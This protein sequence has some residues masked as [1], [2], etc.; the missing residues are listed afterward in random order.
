MSRFTRGFAG[1]GR[2]HDPRL[3]PGQYDTGRS[4]PVLT[5]EVTPRIDTASWTF[6]VEGLV[7]QPTTWTWDQIHALPQADYNGAIHCVTT[8]TKFDMHWSGVAVDTVLAVARPLASASHSS[9]TPTPP[10]P[11]TC[12][13]MTSPAARH[14]SRSKSTE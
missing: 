8:W 4:W 9:P 13:L 1:R 2:Q 12:C 14:G 6:T 7:E 10:T 5:A 11:R 3:P